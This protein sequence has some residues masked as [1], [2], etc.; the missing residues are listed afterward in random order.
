MF[1]PQY[2]QYLFIIGG[3]EMEFPHIETPDI[4]FNELNCWILQI[5]GLPS[6][7]PRW[8]HYV[9]CIR[10]QT[11]GLHCFRPYV[12]PKTHNQEQGLAAD[13]WPFFIA[14]HNFYWI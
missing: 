11:V 7:H 6:C 8:W 13:V 12:P 9:D 14:S 10:D 4:D 3:G 1:T 5:L 2:L